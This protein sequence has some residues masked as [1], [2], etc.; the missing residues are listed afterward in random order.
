MPSRA[1]FAL[2]A[3]APKEMACPPKLVKR[4]LTSEGGGPSASEKR[5]DVMHLKP[6][7]RAVVAAAA[8]FAIVGSVARGESQL[9]ASV[10]GPGKETTFRVSVSEVGDP[11]R[12]RLAFMNGS[13]IVPHVDRRSD[14][15]RTAL[16]NEA[17]GN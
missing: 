3:S 13:H 11:G 14:L 8:L 7:T 1:A 16:V 4:L 10:L 6:A 5:G 15:S 17:H 9:D 12:Y 2:R